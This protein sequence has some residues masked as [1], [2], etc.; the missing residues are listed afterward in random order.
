MFLII[1]S[2][3]V[4]HRYLCLLFFFSR[5]GRREKLK[6]RR[7]QL[8]HTIQKYNSCTHQRGCTWARQPARPGPRIRAPP[9]DPA[10]VCPFRGSGA[11]GPGPWA[12]RSW[13]RGAG[14]WDRRFWALLS[15]AVSPLLPPHVPLTPTNAASD[16]QRPTTSNITQ[17]RTCFEQNVL[18]SMCVICV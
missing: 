6:N 10:L 14:P 7:G 8:S 13:A 5:I 11:R 16:L 15:F 4:K 18:E 12:R 9:G 2:H 17:F 1:T 3:A